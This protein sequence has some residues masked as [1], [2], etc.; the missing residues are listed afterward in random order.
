ME[1]PKHGC[2]FLGEIHRSFSNAATGRVTGIADN[3]WVCDPRHKITRA[4]VH[5]DFEGEDSTECQYY[6]EATEIAKDE[7]LKY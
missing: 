4:G 3:A 5:C 6:E 7:E 2:K 1:W